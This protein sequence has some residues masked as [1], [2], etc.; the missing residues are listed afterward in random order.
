MCVFPL[1]EELAPETP[2]RGSESVRAAITGIALSHHRAR[3]GPIS[4]EGNRS[5]LLQLRVWILNSLAN[6]II[7]IP[8][9]V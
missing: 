5:V 6:C 3:L 7:L 4:E 8:S 2:Q 9:D 1:V